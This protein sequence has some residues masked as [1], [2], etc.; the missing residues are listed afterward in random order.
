MANNDDL[1]PEFPPPKTDGPALKEMLERDAKS[2]WHKAWGGKT[3]AEA[4]A[5]IDEKVKGQ[6]EWGD[7]SKKDSP[8]SD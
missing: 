6:I 2:P 1:P 3:S 8:P 4:R 5:A 7:P